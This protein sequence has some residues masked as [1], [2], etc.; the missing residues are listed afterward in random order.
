MDIY[1]KVKIQRSF[2]KNIDL[3]IKNY[4]QAFNKAKLGYHSISRFSKKN[5]NLKLISE[6]EK[7]FI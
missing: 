2:K 4:K 7:L 5:T 3:I 6:I 1:I